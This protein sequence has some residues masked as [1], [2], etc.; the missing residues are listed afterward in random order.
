VV[1]TAYQQPWC[2]AFIGTTMNAPVCA[3]A[4]AQEGTVRLLS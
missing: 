1:Y 3:G 2:R 4:A